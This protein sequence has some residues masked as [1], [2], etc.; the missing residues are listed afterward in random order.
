MIESKTSVARR[1]VTAG[2]GLRC[3]WASTETMIESHA[4][5]GTELFSMSSVQE[6]GMN[7]LEKKMVEVLKDL[8][9]NHY[10]RG[11]KAEF[12]AEGTRLE[13][14]LRLKEVAMRAGVG[15]TIKIGGCEALRDMY[16]CRVIGVDRVVAPMV[17]SLTAFRKFVAAAKLAFPQDELEDIALAVN[18]ETVDACKAFPSM[19]ATDEIRDV[20]GI[21]MGRTDLTRSLGLTTGDINSRQV[22]EITRDLFRSAKDSTSLV[23]GCGGGVSAHSLPF[24]RELPEGSLDYYETRKVLF[25]CPD[26]LENEA[27]KGILK[28]VGFELL[29]L[30][31]K[32]N[33]YERISLED[34]QR[35]EVMEARYG[36]SIV[37]AGGT[38]E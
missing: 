4:F 10:V 32:Q 2:R 14:A 15:L 31:N 3:C 38:Y 24:F 18:V 17:E 35:V 20:N 21:V 23:C 16:E 13:D 1:C 22:F 6:A 29:W 36:H 12:E 26:A 9:D 28:A 7:S 11:V 19:V 30:K 33:Y 5:R 8:R 34:R 25:Q 27:E 37:Q